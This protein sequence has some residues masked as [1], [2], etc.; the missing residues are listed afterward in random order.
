MRAGRIAA[1]V[2]G[3]VAVALVGAVVVLKSLDFNRY[4]TLITE[5]ARKA[6]GRE[7]TIA[8][9]I[10]LEVSFSPALAVSGVSFANAPWGSSPEMA[11][12]ERFEAQVELL[13]LL[14]G[15]VRVRRL[16][17]VG[18]DLL[19]ETDGDGR[20]NWLME[21]AEAE[22]AEPADGGPI[23]PTFDRVDIRDAVLTYRDGKSGEEIELRLDHLEAGAPDL[24]SP[25]TF[26]LAGG[27]NDIPFSA[28]G[29]VGSTTAL[30]GGGAVALR[31]DA[32]IAGAKAHVE[33]LIAP[34]ET[35]ETALAIDIAGE[36]LAD[37]GPLAGA[38]LP[39]LGPYKLAANLALPPDQLVLT[40][41]EARL[42]KSDLAGK[43]R[44]TF[45]FPM[46]VEAELSSRLIDVDAIVAASG[47][48]GAS[49]GKSSEKRLFSAA[50][51]PCC[52]TRRASPWP[53]TARL[54]CATRASTSSS[55]PDPRTPAW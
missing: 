34:P 43:A 38:A 27:Y 53:A 42:G 33:G 52:S 47:G 46:L 18:A 23:V 2:A 1:I 55:R 21:G 54:I 44:L 25:L 35:G 45:S 26:D 39:A 41:I 51:P 19:L 11:R 37:L 12:I 22:A 16:V 17:L 4:K 24:A 9:D 31:L 5:E 8:G 13:P 3:L 48:G 36:S 20:G 40:D 29:E 28:N 7:L 30:L 10:E 15:D 50:P 6:T 32:A 49:A 14:V